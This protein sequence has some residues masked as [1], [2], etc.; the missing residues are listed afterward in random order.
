MKKRTKIVLSIGIITAGIILLGRVY[1]QRI[2]VTW[3]AFHDVAPSEDAVRE[4]VDRASDPSAAVRRLWDS[5]RIVARKEAVNY[6]RH[7]ATPGSALWPTTRDI[8]LAAARCG[9]QEAQESALA[10]LERVNDPEAMPT[11][12]RWLK[13]VDPETRQF[14]LLF[15]QRQHDKQFAAVYVRMLD[16]NDAKVIDLAS[17]TLSELTGQDFGIRYDADHTS[18]TQPSF[19]SGVAAWK[20]WWQQHRGEFP[21][22]PTEPAKVALGPGVQATDFSLTDLNGSTVR[23]SDFRGKPVL[24][25]FWATWCGSCVHEIPDLVELQRRR[26]ELVILGVA[27]DADPHDEDDEPKGSEDAATRIRRYA[28]EKKINYRVLIDRG[29]AALAPYAGGDLPVSILIDPQGAVR[30]RMI[31]P[32]PLLAW[33]ALVDSVQAAEDK[34]MARA[35]GN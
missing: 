8:V 19:V 6:L 4:A 29:A 18:T 3:L 31:G 17:S 24:I 32:R 5:G 1:A 34:S 25:N 13:D 9:D 33:E 16:D 15:L 11:A 28:T 27:V 26:P 30:R 7:H 10:V 20:S 23:L 22:G 21:A 12:L 2:F 35:T 14:G